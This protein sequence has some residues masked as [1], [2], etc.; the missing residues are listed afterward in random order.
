MA[1]RHSSAFLFSAQRIIF[2]GAMAPKFKLKRPNRD[3]PGLEE[4]MNWW[5]VAK[6]GQCRGLGVREIRKHWK[7]MLTDDGITKVLHNDEE[8]CYLSYNTWEDY[9]PAWRE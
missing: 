8:W 6:E 3:E 5:M 9:M 7:L 4:P 1:R 2:V